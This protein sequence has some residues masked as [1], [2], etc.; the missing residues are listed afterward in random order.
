MPR[1]GAKFSSEELV[2]VLSRYDIGI[3]HQAKPLSVGNSKAPKVVIVAEKGTYLLK[4]RPR[5][6][7]D[8]ERVD[9][10]HAV[11]KQLVGPVF[12]CHEFAGDD[13]RGGYR[14]E[15]GQPHL[16][17]LPVRRGFAV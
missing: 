2:R 9:F 1:G 4:R 17:V 14:A 7:D 6:R 10:A 16:R 13:G 11:Q 15:H 3:V 5:G 8:L 12:P